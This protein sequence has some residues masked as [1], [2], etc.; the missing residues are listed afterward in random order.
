MHISMY[1][2]KGRDRQ[3]QTDKQIDK[4]KIDRSINKDRQI[5]RQIDRQLDSSMDY[6]VFVYGW[7]NQRLKSKPEPFLFSNR[8]YKINLYTYLKRNLIRSFNK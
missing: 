8:V 3:R 5:D 2:Y 4:Y 7:Y 1:T 6:S